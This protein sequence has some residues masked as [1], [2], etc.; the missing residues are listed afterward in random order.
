MERDE[1]KEKYDESFITTKSSGYVT[2]GNKEKVVNSIQSID[3]IL[4]N[5]REFQRAMEVFGED[6]KLHMAMSD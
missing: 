5:H 6:L 1:Y 2:H 4:R 3:K